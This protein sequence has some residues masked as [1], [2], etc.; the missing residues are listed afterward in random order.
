MS[1]EFKR[2]ADVPAVEELTDQDH[3]LAEVGGE[4]VRAPRGEA[5]GGAFVVDLM[6]MEVSNFSSGLGSETYTLEA[7]DEATF[8]GLW[9]AV[10]DGRPICL[11][12]LEEFLGVTESNLE[13]LAETETANE[14]ASESGLVA[15]NFF[16]SVARAG[17]LEAHDVGLVGVIWLAGRH[18]GFG[19]NISL[20]FE[21][22]PAGFTPGPQ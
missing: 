6:G 10:L 11:R 8:S 21:I 16:V 17:R 9:K 22:F 14:E 19:S 1:Y 15:D 4:V 12:N 13:I 7:S 18:P 5:S 3:L 2:L 20:A